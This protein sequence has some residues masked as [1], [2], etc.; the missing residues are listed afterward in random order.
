MN[1][2]RMLNE[3]TEE[4]ERWEAIDETK[5]WEVVDE[6]K[7]WEELWRG[8]QTGKMLTWKTKGLRAER[9]VAGCNFL[10]LIPKHIQVKN[11]LQKVAS[12]WML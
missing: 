5:G 1:S 7:S 2:S 3:K 11:L 8:L 6:T 10:H 12:N 4:G 9:L